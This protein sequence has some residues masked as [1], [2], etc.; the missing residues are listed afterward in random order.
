[1]KER[2][3]GVLLNYVILVISIGMNFLYVP[4]LLSFV[5][6]SEYGIYQ[7]IGALVGYISVLEGSVAITVTQFYT[8][9]KTLQQYEAM[10]NFLAMAF[11]I[12]FF[13]SLIITIIAVLMYNYLGDMFTSVMTWREVELVKKMFVLLVVNILIS[14]LFSPINSV[15]ISHEKFRFQKILSLLQTLL[16]PILVIVFLYKYP[17]SLT[18]VVIQTLFNL[19][20]WA[21]KVYYVYCCLKIKV[22]YHYWDWS[23]VRPFFS[24]TVSIL[25]VAIIDQVFFRT[26]QLILGFLKGPEVVTLYAIAATIYIQY[27]GLANKISD[28]FGPKVVELVSKNESMFEVSKLFIKIGRWQWFILGYILTSF[29]IFGKYFIQIWVGSSF[30]EAYYIALILITPFSIDLVQN[31]GNT[32]LQAKNKYG[33]RAKV[34]WCVGIMCLGCSIP[35]TER[36]GPIGTALCTGISWFIISG[37][38]INRYYAKVIGLNIG[39]FWRQLGVVTLNMLVVFFPMLIY[40]FCFPITSMVQFLICLI[41]YSLFYIFILYKRCLNLEEK[42]FI[43][44]IVRKYILKV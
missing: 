4:I 22:V 15:I 20:L 14:I 31:L 34:F 38:I 6:K 10:E 19:I 30:I 12:H 2:F 37:I 32:I 25:G 36:W 16:Q 18:I 33:Y 35:V 17:T 11:R 21:G 5:G 24:L 39:E 8:R 43:D 27:M 13:V 40:S 3:Y 29:I 1:M 23:I 42:M 9:Y 26:N 28:V 44:N 7:L 41:I